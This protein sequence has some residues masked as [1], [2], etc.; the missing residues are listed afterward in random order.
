MENE[1]LE[2]IGL[3]WAQGELEEEE[4]SECQPELLLSCRVL[5]MHCEERR[6]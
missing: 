1:D 3:L 2:Q 5:W 6:V 4:I